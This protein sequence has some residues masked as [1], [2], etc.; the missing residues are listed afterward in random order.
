MWVD[1]AFA[2]FVMQWLD[3]YSDHYTGGRLSIS[4]NTA[5]HY[6]FY[7]ESRDDHRMLRSVRQERDIKKGRRR[8]MPRH[9]TESPL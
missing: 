6:D 1:R 5:R 7:Q 9:L 3:R 2:H 4:D 8:T